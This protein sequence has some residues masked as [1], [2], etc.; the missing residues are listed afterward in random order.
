MREE[1]KEKIT[2]LVSELLNR[3]GIKAGVKVYEEDETIKIDIEGDNLGILIG[4]HGVTLRTLQLI[5][6]MMVG[7]QLGE[8][9]QVVVDI[10]GWRLRRQ[11]QLER[12]ATRA[13]EEVVLT[14]EE[15]TLPSMSAFE[16][17]IIHLA[18]ASDPK[19]IT[20]SV[21]EEPDRYVTIKP[22]SA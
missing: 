16:R 21:G 1:E 13:A 10:N 22:K 19:V 4:R 14:N 8:W 5:I 9:Q 18:L 20:E 12:M 3:I 17:R 2:G 11:E 7:K 15:R 6:S